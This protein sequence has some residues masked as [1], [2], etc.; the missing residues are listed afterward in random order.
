MDVMGDSL[1]SD[2]SYRLLNVRHE[3]NRGALVI[4]VDFSLP[5]TRASPCW[6]I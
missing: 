1:Y 2:R 5:S 4:E 3:E 6:M